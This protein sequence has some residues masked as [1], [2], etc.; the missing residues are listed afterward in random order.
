MIGSSSRKVAPGTQWECSDI[1]L[2]FWI[3]LDIQYE[4]LFFPEERID[5]SCELVVITEN[6]V[7]KI[8]VNSIGARGNWYTINK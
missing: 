8:P 7:F 6:E 2:P 4:V 5:Y 1:D 3:G